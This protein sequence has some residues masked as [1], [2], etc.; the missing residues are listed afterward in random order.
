M[1]VALFSVEI[2]RWL[3]IAYALACTIYLVRY[4]MDLYKWNPFKEP[5]TL[6]E[7]EK[8]I[9]LKWLPVYGQMSASVKRRFEKRTVWY[10]MAKTFKFQGEIDYQEDVKL[11]LSGSLA[12]MTL[13]ITSY[14]MMT[15]LVE[16]VIYPTQYYSRI[17]RQ[18]H[19]GEYN[20]GLKRV[21]VSSDRLWKGFEITDDNRNLVVHEFA[22]ALSFHLIKQPFGE[23]IRFRN[24][25][26]RIKI[27][28]A[29][30]DFSTRMENSNYFRDYGKTNLQEFFSVAVENFIETP[31]VFKADFPELYH[32]IKRM[33]NFDFLEDGDAPIKTAP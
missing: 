24:G 15:S 17:K 33:L 3:W 2:F 21:I 9:L 23:G 16:I 12:L 27:L 19:V 7:S 11:L 6:S 22:H 13:G 8:R 14:Q 29:R 30:P 20:L 32:I 28:L 1:N 31:N 25:L 4:A 26:K 5:V 18:Y 10:R